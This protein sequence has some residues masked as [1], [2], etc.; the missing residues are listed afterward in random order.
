M[1][2][3]DDVLNSSY[4]VSDSWLTGKKEINE[5]LQDMTV[6]TIWITNHKNRMDASTFRRFQYIIKFG[7]LTTKQRE[8]VWKRQI[9]INKASKYFSD[10]NLYEL[11]SKYEVLNFT[12]S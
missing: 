3:S 5:L 8:K 7:K 12:F 11:S 1:D 10:I 6:P 4:G 9:E 2:E